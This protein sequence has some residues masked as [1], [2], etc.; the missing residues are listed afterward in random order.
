M[1]KNVK[2][3]YAIAIIALLAVILIAYYQMLPESTTD[4][5]KRD[6]IE[7]LYMSYKKE[8]P[9]IQDVDPQEAMQLANTG[10]VVFIDVRKP[11]EQRE[12]HLPGAIT[13]DFFLENPEKNCE[14]P[15]LH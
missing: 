6:Q 12:S 8:F 4:A 14:M 10:K 5:Q 11:N 1:L 3:Y 2:I 15:K 13:A 7:K 9:E